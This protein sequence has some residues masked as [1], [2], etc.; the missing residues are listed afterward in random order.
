[1]QFG[2]WV[3]IP[4]GLALVMSRKGRIAARQ[5]WAK[6]DGRLLM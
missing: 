4:R 1:M 6:A 5:P 3:R 2:K